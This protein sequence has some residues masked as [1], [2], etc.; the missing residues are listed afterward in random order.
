[1]SR[2]RG[3]AFE[4]LDVKYAAAVV[5]VVVG[6]VW[7]MRASQGAAAW[8]QESFEGL[9]S[10]ERS[11][12]ARIDWERLRALGVNVG[13]AYRGLPNA[14]AKAQYRREFLEGFAKA[15]AQGGGRPEAFVDWRVEERTGEEIVVA[16]DYPAKR[17]TLLISLPASGKRRIAGLAWKRPCAD[18]SCL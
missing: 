11:A 16:A 10:G 6:L 2:S 12:Q 8:C 9:T 3:R 13:A 4:L 18:G 5:A 15:F 1:M 17:N 7:A 14:H